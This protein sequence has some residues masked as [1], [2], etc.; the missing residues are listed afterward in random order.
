MVY[1]V[2]SSQTSSSGE[3]L[4]LWTYRTGNGGI[5]AVLSRDGSTVAAASSQQVILLNRNGQL[6]WKPSVPGRIADVA[7][8]R[9]GS[10]LLLA[11]GGVAVLNRSGENKRREHMDVRNRRGYRV[12]LRS[13][14][15]YAISNRRVRRE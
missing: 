14:C 10:T 9:D 5:K 11:N 8:S 3:G 15:E 12:G 7:I 2:L 6:L 4:L 1:T 13:I